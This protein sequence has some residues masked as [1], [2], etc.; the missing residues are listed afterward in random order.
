MSLFGHS[1]VL[2]SI[3]FLIVVVAFSMLSFQFPSLVGCLRTPIIHTSFN[4]IPTITLLL[5]H[6]LYLIPFCVSPLLSLHF[7]LSSS[8]ALRK[9]AHSKP[10]FFPAA[11]PPSFSPVSRPP[12][13]FSTVHTDLSLCFTDAVGCR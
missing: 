11:T 1:N 13:L 3:F 5:K 12:P 10:A 2:V 9:Y 4:L 7:R 6:N 8:F